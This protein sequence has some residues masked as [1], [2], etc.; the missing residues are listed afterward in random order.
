M[1]NEFIWKLLEQVPD[2]EIP[3]ISVVELGIIRAVEVEGDWV[4]VTL[5]PTFSGCP[6][7]QFIQDHVRSHLEASGVKAV[8]IQL[9]HNPP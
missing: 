4:R 8:E 2:P 1:T 9:T 3:V 5:T 7:L 6:A